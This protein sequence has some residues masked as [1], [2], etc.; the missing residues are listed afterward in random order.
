MKTM[1]KHKKMNAP[2][3][4]DLKDMAKEETMDSTVKGKEAKKNQE[5]A[6]NEEQTEQILTIIK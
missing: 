5:Q 4:D 1:L 6:A 2:K 3:K